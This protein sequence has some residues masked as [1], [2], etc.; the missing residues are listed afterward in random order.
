MNTFRSLDD[1][2]LAVGELVLCKPSLD[3]VFFS[4]TGHHTEDTQEEAA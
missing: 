2:G 1:A 3:E 4:L